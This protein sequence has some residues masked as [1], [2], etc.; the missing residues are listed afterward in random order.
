MDQRCSCEDRLR[1]QNRNLQGTSKGPYNTQFICVC[2]N[3]QVEVRDRSH[4][5]VAQED[6]SLGANSGPCDF[7]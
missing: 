6:N 5:V 3:A 1:D 7:W 2:R 4:W